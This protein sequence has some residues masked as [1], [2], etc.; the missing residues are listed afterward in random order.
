M[1]TDMTARFNKGVLVYRCIS[2]TYGYIYIYIY[3]Y[4]FTTTKYLYLQLLLLPSGVEAQLRQGGDDLSAPLPRET[5]EPRG[6][7]S[8]L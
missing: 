7:Y 1:T 8:V 4:I 6:E 2:R 3:I 5:V